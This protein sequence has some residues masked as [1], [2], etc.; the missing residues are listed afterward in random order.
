MLD[1][2]IKGIEQRFDELEGRSSDPAVIANQREYTALAKE[3]SQMAEVAGAVREY[4]KVSDEIAEYKSYMDGDDVD[5]REL[6]KSEMPELGRRQAA[7]EE[8]I[9]VLLTPRDPN[10]DKNVI[11]EIRAGTG[12]AEASL[13]AAELFRLYTR[14]AERHRWKVE[15]LSLSDTG[16]GGIKEV[17][18]SINGKGAYSRLKYEG[19]VH[20]VQRV[21]ATE[22]SGRIHTSAVTVVV[23]PEADEVEINI[24][25]EKDL[26]I[27]VMRA[28]GPGG[29]S[30][31][32][33]DSGG[34]HYAHSQRDGDYLPR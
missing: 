15:T 8:K 21:P 29:Q 22:A 34:A 16:L 13:F 3:R 9:R 19:G 20:R 17:V 10:D 4:R 7:L 33:T 23:M 28:S 5:M 26:R 31:N 32:T 25:E 30:V 27:D 14:Y 11:L 12:G 1:D 18:A 24:N 6:A 2:K